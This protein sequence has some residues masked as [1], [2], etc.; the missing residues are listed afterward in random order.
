MFF[1]GNGNND[2]DVGGSTTH[3]RHQ[4][5]I[6]PGTYFVTRILLKALIVGLAILIGTGAYKLWQWCRS[7]AKKQ[8]ETEEKSEDQ[9]GNVQVYI[10]DDDDDDNEDDD[11]D[12]DDDD[13]VTTDDVTADDVML[14]PRQSSAGHAQRQELQPLA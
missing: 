13:D 5:S 14:V 8:A 4:V 7:K 3:N 6:D 11:D 12:D 1:E 2:M 9:T 10:D